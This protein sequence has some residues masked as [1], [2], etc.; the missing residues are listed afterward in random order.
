MESGNDTSGSSS[1]GDTKRVLMWCAAGVLLVGV[2]VV[3]CVFLWKAHREVSE[4]NSDSTGDGEGTASGPTPGTAPAGGAG[5]RDSAA[6]AA[7]GTMAAPDM[8]QQAQSVADWLQVLFSKL[9]AGFADV[10]VTLTE[11]IA[12]PQQ[13]TT[14]SN[15]R[16]NTTNNSSNSRYNSGYDDNT[17]T[18]RDYVG[19]SNG[20]YA[21]YDGEGQ[22]DSQGDGGLL[23]IGEIDD[24]N[25]DV[26]DVTDVTD[27]DIGDMVTEEVD[28][29]GSRRY[30]QDV[31]K[32]ISN[33]PQG[34]QASTKLLLTRFA[35]DQ[36]ENQMIRSVMGGIVKV[37]NRVYRMSTS[38]R[39]PQIRILLYVNPGDNVLAPV[40]P[41]FVESVRA[42]VSGLRSRKSCWKTARIMPFYSTDYRNSNVA[43]LLWSLCIKSFFASL[44]AGDKL[45]FFILTHGGINSEGVEFVLGGM[46]ERNLT[47]IA[48]QVPSEIELFLYTCGCEQ[49]SL[50]DLEHHITVDERGARISYDDTPPTTKYV[51]DIITLTDTWRGFLSQFEPPTFDLSIA[52]PDDLAFCPILLNFLM[53]SYDALRKGKKESVETYSTFF[54][55]YATSGWHPLR[56]AEV[57]AGSS[58]LLETRIM[59]GTWN[60]FRPVLGFS[61]ANVINKACE[62]WTC[63]Q[64]QV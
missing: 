20:T 62:H 3:I 29:S 14:V 1:N 7:T 37:Q 16:S 9:P 19:I 39:P 44:V 55:A 26:T 42:F 36:P 13:A 15:T 5:K 49:S 30:V 58:K 10:I 23:D 22:G 53:S 41:G 59:D 47:E 2:I 64:S 8:D 54:D 33:M 12:S 61:G 27:V 4:E 63:V 51:A 17:T 34:L 35:A 18:S 57:P 38:W 48:K 46:D 25:A 40:T 50:I 28:P 60:M 24:V 21:R 6:K 31:S 52:P 45:V 32:D 56:A 11:A 43:K